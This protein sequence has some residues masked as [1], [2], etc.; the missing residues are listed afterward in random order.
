MLPATA[1][2]V[3]APVIDPQAELVL[4]FDGQY[5][6]PLDTGDRIEIVRAPRLLRLL[7]VSRRTHFDMLREK[8]KWG[9]A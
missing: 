8:L 4:T 9:N 1:R 2:I 7:R 6:V 3:L 5:G